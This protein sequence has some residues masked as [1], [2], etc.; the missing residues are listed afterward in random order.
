MGD[1]IGLGLFSMAICFDFCSANVVQFSN[2]RYT[3]KYTK[4]SS[5]L[6]LSLVYFF[7]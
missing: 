4:D 3:E 7:V 2:V 1:D 5:V 6:L